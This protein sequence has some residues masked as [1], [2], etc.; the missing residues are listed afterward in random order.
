MDT[1]RLRDR[2]G[3]TPAWNANECV[4]DLALGLRAASPSGSG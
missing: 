2:W 1:S 3:C 4:E